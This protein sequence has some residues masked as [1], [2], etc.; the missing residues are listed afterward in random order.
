MIERKTSFADAPLF[1]RRPKHLPPL[2]ILFVS[3]REGFRPPGS[4]ASRAAGRIYGSGLAFST[5]PFAANGTH[6]EMVP[7]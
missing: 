4:A 3:S 5:V 1:P 7:P 2:K 6:Q